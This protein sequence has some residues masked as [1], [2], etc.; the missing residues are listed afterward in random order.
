MSLQAAFPAFERKSFVAFTR[1]PKQPTK[2][3][4][5]SS[6]RPAKKPPA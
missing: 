1:E 3:S 5:K 2:A 6:K 4:G